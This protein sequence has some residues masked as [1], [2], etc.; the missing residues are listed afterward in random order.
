M[1]YY[2]L[3][4]VLLSM[5]YTTF[6]NTVEL[7][8][9]RNG[10]KWG[11]A[12]KQGY[13]VIKCKYTYVT[14]FKENRARV[15]LPSG[16]IGFISWPGLFVTILPEYATC[17]S[18]SEGL[19]A[20]RKLKQNKWGFIDKDYNNVIKCQY[21]AVGDFHEG[22]A[23]VRKNDKYGYIDKNGKLVIAHQFDV[24]S[25]FSEGL[26]AVK[27]KGKYGYINTSGK[28]V[29]PFSFDN[30][31]KFS[32]SLAPVAIGKGW[33]YINKSGKMVIPP[34]YERTR[35]F[36]DGLAIV[37]GDRNKFG[38]IDNSGKF[39]I[40][41]DKFRSLGDFSNGIAYAM[42]FIDKHNFR[43]G[44]IDTT[45]KTI[46]P[47][48]YISARNFDGNIARVWTK[49]RVKEEYKRK[50]FHTGKV[51]KWYGYISAGGGYIDRSGN[52]FWIDNA[53]SGSVPNGAK[54]RDKKHS[55]SRDGYGDNQ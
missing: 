32:E 37:A 40:P 5:T 10:D 13:I 7:F 31:Q 54:I 21:S 6:S 45:G 43:Y 14:P 53:G 34:K 39:I 18:F 3:I 8:P 4:I 33:G 49:K 2:S 17:R 51:V 29:I 36:N 50:I 35:S 24:A 12:S 46:I 9:F 16:E 19:A 47:F 41:F 28:V 52:E 44:Y 20:C 23:K 38:A 42:K 27:S 26:A 30:A 25:D 11:F 48:K 22:Y 15:K 55:F 1:K